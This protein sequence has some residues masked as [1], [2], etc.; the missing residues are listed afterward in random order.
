MWGERARDAPAAL[1]LV[2]LR[3]CRRDDL[4]DRDARVRREDRIILVVLGYHINHCV[5]EPLAVAQRHRDGPVDQHR[6]LE[7]IDEAA[8]PDGVLGDDRHA[9]E[10]N[11]ACGGASAGPARGGRRATLRAAAR[12]ALL[13]RTVGA[14]ALC[15]HAHRAD[16]EAL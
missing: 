6:L 14:E 11:P 8:T 9:L 5:D 1:T 4:S 10:D 2:R 3:A 15:L 7:H 13:R 16:G 12:S